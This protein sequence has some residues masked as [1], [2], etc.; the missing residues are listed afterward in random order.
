MIE[1]VR[2]DLPEELDFVEA[3]DLTYRAL[4]ERLDGL[5]GPKI[6]LLAKLCLQ[7][8]GPLASGKRRL[9]PTLEEADIIDAENVVRGVL[10]EKAN[11]RA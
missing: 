3:Y 8:G 11:T 4:T 7:N 2:K 1:T 9:F 10:A 5:P 6:S